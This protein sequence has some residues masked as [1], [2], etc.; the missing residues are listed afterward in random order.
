VVSNTTGRWDWL[1]VALDPSRIRATVSHFPLFDAVVLHPE[2]Y[3]NAE[4]SIRDN[5]TEADS[6]PGREHGSVVD[7]NTDSDVSDDELSQDSSV[8]ESPPRFQ[9]KKNQRLPP[10]HGLSPGVPWNKDA[11]DI[12]YSPGF[13]LPIILGAV[14]SCLLDNHDDEKSSSGGAFGDGSDDMVVQ[15]KFSKNFIPTVHGLCEKGVVSLCLAS[16]ASDCREVRQHAIA[17]LGIFILAINT[18]EA[19]KRGSWRERPQLAMILN[20]V[21][22]AYVLKRADQGD[23]GN[24]IPVL[25]PLV[26]TFLARAS[27]SVSKPGDALFPALNHYFL[28]SDKEHG[29]FQDMNRLPGFMSL[30]CSS[31]EDS[32]IARKERIWALQTLRDGF[33]HPSC[34]RL[35]STCHAPELILTSFE[36]VRLGKT[37][38]EMKGQEFSLLLEVLR[39]VIDYGGITSV[40][41][42][43][44]LVGLFSWMRSICVARNLL[45]TFPTIAARRA[46][47]DLVS[48]AV[49]AASVDERLR[50]DVLLHEISML[51]QSVLDICNIT[52]SDSKAVTDSTLVHSSCCALDALGSAFSSVRDGLGTDDKMHYTGFIIASGLHFLKDVPADWQIKTAAA[53]SIVPVNLENV[54]PLE[55]EAF[56]SMLLR[57]TASCTTETST[58]ATLKR[59]A[60]VGQMFQSSIAGDSETLRILLLSRA[61]A[62]TSREAYSMWLKCVSVFSSASEISSE[63]AVARQ[64]LKNE[65]NA[66]DIG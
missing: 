1:L 34:Y 8:P 47:C 33:L 15:E 25:S 30:F 65:G 39:K 10:N 5:T 54:T 27:I 45:E 48:S 57:C 62:K 2:H 31:V 22:R 59:I 36:N 40:R 51:S 23:S 35:V 19:R 53:L 50:T 18:E 60:L 24:S 7:N 55:A 12:R 66:M 3:R 63:V 56:C 46:F 6:T 58:I 20:S 41:H 28:K 38:V 11:R 9:K 26:S 43:V 4:I 49:T 32:S 64:L 17:I 13:L 14:E 52:A 42:L 29:A 37:T 61:K 44:K 21:Q 16:L